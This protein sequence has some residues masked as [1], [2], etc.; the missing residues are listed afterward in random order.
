MHEFLLKQKK[1]VRFDARGRDEIKRG[2]LFS[3]SLS[4]DN[5]KRNRNR[6][7][8]SSMRETQVVAARIKM[9]LIETTRHWSRGK[10]SSLKAA[11]ESR[12]S[13]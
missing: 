10:F 6:R 2:T 5:G 1:L 8:V 11:S 13:V 7:I 12:S 4:G 3:I 9:E